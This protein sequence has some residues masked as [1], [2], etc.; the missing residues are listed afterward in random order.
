MASEYATGMIRSTMSAVPARTPAFAAKAIILAVVSYVIT[1]VAGAV[2]FLL[3]VPM[4]QGL[5][6]TSPGPLTA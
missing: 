2:T 6:L 4:F 3:S 5:G 1:T